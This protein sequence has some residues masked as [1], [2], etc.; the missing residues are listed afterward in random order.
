MSTTVISGL[1]IETIPNE[2]IMGAMIQEG[3][4]EP[5]S[6]PSNWKDKEKIDAN[7]A[8]QQKRWEEGLAKT[9]S[10][11]PLM[12][13]MCCVAMDDGADLSGVRCL[14]DMDADYREDPDEAE[15]Q[16]LQEMW[17]TL[18]DV[19]G[20]ITCNGTKFDV[21]F[22]NKRSAILG[23]R[24]LK[25]FTTPRYRSWPNFDI[26]RWAD[27]WDNQKLKGT[28]L[29]A[30]CR[31]FGLDSKVGDMDGSQV[32]GMYLDERWDEIK[33][34]NWAMDTKPLPKV[35]QRIYASGLVHMPEPGKGRG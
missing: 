11:S 7:I 13:R 21:P 26:Q 23:V 1:D 25:D 34:Y 24:V 30:I 2:T 20:I 16:L 27:D 3:P 14:D 17:Q 6:A 10:L 12:G 9:C 4:D 8:D 19:T 28:N 5:F 35:F 32:Y 22:M 29:K 18:K 33:E 15:R 31:A